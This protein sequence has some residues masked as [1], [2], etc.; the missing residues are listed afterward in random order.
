MLARWH[1]RRQDLEWHLQPR[2]EPIG[3]WSP[4]SLGA[5]FGDSSNVDVTNLEADDAGTSL[6]RYGQGRTN[7]EPERCPTSSAFVVVG[8]LCTDL[9]AAVWFI[10]YVNG[11]LCI[12]PAAAA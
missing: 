8:V 12:F 5:R 3:P 10:S 4:G 9:W 1:R 7:G 6:L 11:D 2:C